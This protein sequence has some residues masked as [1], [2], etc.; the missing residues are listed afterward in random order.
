MLAPTVPL[1]FRC[2]TTLPL[3]LKMLAVR[4]H[5]Q[6]GSPHNQELQQRADAW[7]D[8]DARGSAKGLLASIRSHR[9]MCSSMWCALTVCSRLV[10]PWTREMCVIKS[11]TSRSCR[12]EYQA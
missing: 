10:H 1:L 3:L 6:M 4:A 2:C 8:G 9:R 11:V 5:G 7:A 12:C